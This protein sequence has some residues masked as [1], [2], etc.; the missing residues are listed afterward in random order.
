MGSPIVYRY[1]DWSITVPLQMIEFNLILKAAGKATSA[2]MFWRLLFGTVMMLLFGYL[3]EIHVIPAATGFVLGLCGWGFILNEIF[4]GEAGGVAADCLPAVATSF[5]NM[6]LIV[7]VGWSIYP[8]GY[9]FGYLLGTV[10]DVFLNVI[11]NIADLLNKIGF[12]LSCWACAKEDSPAWGALSELLYQ[13]PVKASGAAGSFDQGA[14]VEAATKLIGNH[15]YVVKD[16]C[17]ASPISQR[18][19]S[20]MNA[21]SMSDVDEMMQEVARRLLGRR[22]STGG[23]A[24]WQ[25]VAAYLAS[26]T[27][28]TAQQCPG[29]K[30]DMSEKAAEA[31]LAVVKE[32]GS[33]A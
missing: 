13:P 32:V 12:V 15:D 14:L 31:F 9:L 8:L 18:E 33:G 26:R 11:Y 1:V 4:M 19:L 5:S 2:G 21:A 25:G 22:G 27:Q 20:R 6:R 16:I 24:V 3:G 17:S 7:T 23:S 28:S 29:R 30:P 10:D